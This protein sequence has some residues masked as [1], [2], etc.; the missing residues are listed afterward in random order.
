MFTTIKQAYQ[1]EAK[2]RANIDF[3]SLC[4]YGI[5]ALDD[6]LLAIAPKELVVIAAGSGIGKT[7]LSLLISQTAV[8][9]GKKT[10]HYNLEGGVCEAVQRLK[11]QHMCNIYYSEYK[12][13]GVEM[14]YRRWVL[15]DNPDPLF[16]KLESLAYN[17]ILEVAE[18]RLYL[19]DNPEGLNCA[20][21]CESLVRLEGLR[22]DMGADPLLRK[23]MK[24]IVGID[25]IVIDHLHYFSLTKDENEISEITEILKVIKIITEELHIPVVLVAHLRKLQRG[26]GV[27]D[28]E[29]IYGTGN[30]HKIANTCLILSPDHENDKIA[31]GIYPTFIR[32]AKSRQGLRSNLLIKTDFNS[33]SRKYSDKYELYRCGQLGDPHGEPLKENEKPNWAKDTLKGMK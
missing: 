31:D 3:K 28:K 18:D 32:I 25:L 12:D 29:D 20:S 24:G 30:T 22:A 17:K 2:Y 11:W 27:P 23:H 26:H 19:Y 5:K 9:M 14:D 33:H 13:E 6:A 7:E 16:T 1:D 8:S 4:K 15:N 10:A 21:F